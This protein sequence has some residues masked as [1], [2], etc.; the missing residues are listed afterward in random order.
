MGLYELGAEAENRTWLEA[1]RDSPS[2]H[3]V[4]IKINK[5]KANLVS[6]Q[7]I[8]LRVELG[9]ER[10]SRAYVTEVFTLDPFAWAKE[11]PEALAGGAIGVTFVL[12]LLGLFGWAPLTIYALYSRWP[13]NEALSG[14]T[15]FVSIPLRVVGEMT[16]LPL[17]ARRPRV[18]DAWVRTHAASFLL[19]KPIFI[20]LPVLHGK[21]EVRFNESG[22][23]RFL[24]E[25]AEV[26]RS[27]RTVL[28][29][30]QGGVGKTT[31]LRQLL[32]WIGDGLVLGHSAI[33]ILV[34]SDK[35]PVLTEDEVLDGL[36]TRFVS[37]TG[38]EHKVP[39]AFLRAL[40]KS[41]RVVLAF[42]H[43][44]E[45]SEESIAKITSLR[46]RVTVQHLLL[47]SRT[48]V[49]VLDSKTLELSPALLGAKDLEGF[50]GKLLPKETME[51]AERAAEITKTLATFLRLNNEVRVPAIV[52]WLFVEPLR[53]QSAPELKMPE[54]I[55]GLYFDFVHW[56]VDRAVPHEHGARTLE[57]LRE[58][59]AASVQNG[60]IENVREMAA[61][62]LVNTAGE[63]DLLERL[64]EAGL[65]SQSRVRAES[66]VRFALDPVAEYLAMQHRALAT[67]EQAKKTDARATPWRQLW[68]ELDGASALHETLRRIVASA[69]E[70]YE[71]ADAEEFLRAIADP[72]P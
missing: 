55:A 12:L 65:L 40:L 41:G 36:S 58:L 34:D 59:A 14:V 50:V 52:V 63:V 44:S 24:F 5:A 3:E 48:R 56:H 70:A 66:Y 22:K 17:L 64:I 19:E 27:P 53:A 15:S 62:A 49:E 35:D 69:P 9:T 60:R 29:S 71:F 2:D 21:N 39:A 25:G 1:E 67:R 51:D 7:R 68:K 37:V 30:G 6:G 54:T 23:A 20:D 47:T 26:A 13:S 18:L 57:S 8:R 38:P 42:D 11:Y 16:L 46:R 45:L 72:S 4:L 43:V 10:Y 61:R 32:S 33:P 31:L 28:I